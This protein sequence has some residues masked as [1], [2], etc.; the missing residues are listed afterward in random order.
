MTGELHIH[1][2]GTRRGTRIEVDGVP[3]T[4]VQRIEFTADI[5]GHPSLILHVRGAHI[6][7][8]IPAEDAE[9]VGAS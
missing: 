6:D 9:I 1:G 5:T 8:T 2:D 4:G 7:V 3:I